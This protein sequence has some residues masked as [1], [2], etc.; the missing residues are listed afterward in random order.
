MLRKMEGGRAI[1][2]NLARRGRL[3]IED[4]M[5]HHGRLFDWPRVLFVLVD[6]ARVRDAR[7][8]ILIL[9]RW[10]VELL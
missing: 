1:K 6:K 3:R 4:L 2:L 8:A 7:K 9:L 10:E 5:T